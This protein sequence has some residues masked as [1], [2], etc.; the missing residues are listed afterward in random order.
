MCI[1]SKMSYHIYLVFICIKLYRAVWPRNHDLLNGFRGV[2]TS[3]QSM[4]NPSFYSSRNSIKRLQPMMAY[5]HI[6]SRES[7][8]LLWI[9]NI[10]L[11]FIQ[12]LMFASMYKTCVT[13]SE[14]KNVKELCPQQHVLHQPRSVCIRT[15]HLDGSV[16]QQWVSQLFRSQC[17]ASCG[18]RAEN[19]NP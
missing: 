10:K 12:C 13:K 8:K 6:C 1:Y 16:Q 3:W 18:Q 4:S 19:I 2:V 9:Q 17:H 14:I 11:S 7:S 5:A 15:S